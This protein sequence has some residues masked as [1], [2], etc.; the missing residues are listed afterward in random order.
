MRAAVA[1]VAAVSLVCAARVADAGAP[2][3]DRHLGPARSVAVLTFPLET[4]MTA[5]FYRPALSVQLRTDLGAK[6]ALTLRVTG[7]WYAAGGLVDDH[8]GGFGLALGVQYYT[9]KPL[10]GPFFGLEGGD[11]EIFAG[12]HHGR[13]YGGSFTFGYGLAFQDGWYLSFGLGLGYW[14]REGIIDKGPTFPEIM[15]LRLGVGWGG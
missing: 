13:S 10:S 2:R 12:H 9:S 3:K 1:L 14:H 6:V 15:S 4:L 5:A 8:A 7:I 11:V